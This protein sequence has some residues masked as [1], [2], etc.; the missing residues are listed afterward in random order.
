MVVYLIS[1]VLF[2]LM[3]KLDM[4]DGIGMMT[5]ALA[6]CLFTGANL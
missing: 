1:I 2:A 4:S 3:L 6:W 5:L